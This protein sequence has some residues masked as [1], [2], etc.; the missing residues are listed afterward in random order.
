MACPVNIYKSC[1]EV[2]CGWRVL[3]LH[4]LI[5]VLCRGIK[6]C[7]RCCMV[8]VMACED[9]GH[10]GVY[11]CQTLRQ[12]LYGAGKWPVKTLVILVCTGVTPY[13]RC[14]MVQVMA[15][16]ALGHLGVYRCQ[17]LRQVLYGAGN[18]L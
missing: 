3:R 1:Y 4:L 13:A 2:T 15:R 6:P 14:C 9:F 5:M 17:N 18:G 8:Q 11:R 16:E 7:A 10:L 12:V